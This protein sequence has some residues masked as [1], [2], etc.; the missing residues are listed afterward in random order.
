MNA[1]PMAFAIATFVPLPLLVA[2]ALFGGWA[3]WIALLYITL[4][5]AAVDEF[6]ASLKETSDPEGDATMISTGL[7]VAHF[8]LLVL[9]IWS[10]SG[11]GT[12]LLSFDG[13]ALF[14]AAG[15][16][17]GQVSNSNAHELIHRSERGL[18]RLGKWVYISMLFGHHTSAHPLVHHVHV[19]TAK[20][21]STSRLGESFWRFAKRAWVGSFT[22]GYKAETA[23]RTKVGLPATGIH[24][25]YTTY[26]AGS[27]GL[28]AVSAII[29]GWR[30]VGIHLALA[31]FA[32]I[33]LL[34]SDYVQHYGLERREVEPG[35]F[36]PLGPQH[37]WNAPHL[38][39]SLWMLNAPRHSDHHTNP[40]KQFPQLCMPAPGD[41][42][43]LP[44][45]LPFMAC[46]ALYPSLWRRVMNP[47]AEAWRNV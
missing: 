43:R 15:L 38:L 18:R 28:L 30:G 7:A 24:H 13:I 26:L 1:T 31:G 47:L 36:E 16:F 33:Q 6:G 25:P 46:M 40:A 23:R 9:V 37:S 20:D 21:P 41:A 39:S 10:L 8:V 44:H 27:V 12:R 42:P 14:I 19:G 35:T 11:N 5:V 45:A 4:F 29:A 34:L 22:A 17:M 2:G 3:P 32:Q